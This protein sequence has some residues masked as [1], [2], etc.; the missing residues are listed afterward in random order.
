MKERQLFLYI[1]AV[2]AV[3]GFTVNFAAAERAI[4]DADAEETI[5]NPGWANS[6]ADDFW[7]ENPGEQ[8]AELKVVLGDKESK[9]EQLQANE[10]RFY[11]R[12]EM[13]SQSKMEGGQVDLDDV[14]TIFNM[15]IDSKIKMT[16]VE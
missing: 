10:K 6:C 16:C 4:G 12:T 7:I 8:M 13:L 1:F 3:I 5:L 15:D 2:I 11:S 14:L 9:N